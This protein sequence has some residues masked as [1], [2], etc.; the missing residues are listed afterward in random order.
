MMK[1]IVNEESKSTT[2]VA[3]ASEL[4]ESNTLAQNFSNLLSRVFAPKYPI[5]EE[6]EEEAEEADGEEEEE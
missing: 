2:I 6:E 3:N 4:S 5:Y 1:I